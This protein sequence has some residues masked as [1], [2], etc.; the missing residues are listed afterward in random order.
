G[1]AGGTWTSGNTAV[2]SVDAAT[3]AV[4]GVAAGSTN[5][6]Y[7]STNGCGSARASA[8]IVVNPLP[9]AGTITE[10]A[11]AD[12]VCS[13]ATLLVSA[14]G[15]AGG[16]WSS[17]DATIASIDAAGN[18]YAG[19][20]GSATLT[21]LVTNG[22]DR[23]SATYNVRT[24][25][26]PATAVI[27]GHTTVNVGDTIQLSA[28]VAG[29]TWSSD[30]T[31]I[32]TVDPVGV[33]T[34]V[35]D[36]TTTISYTTTTFCGS[37]YGLYSVT[38]STPRHAPSFDSGAAVHLTVCENA[39][40]TSINSL[41][42]TTD[43][44]AGDILTFS[45]LS[46]AS[47]GTAAMSYVTSSTGVSLVPLTASYTPTTGYSGADAFSVLVSDGTLSDTI[48]V[49]VTVNPL[50]I[51]GTIS[52]AAG[53]TSVC[54]G[55]NLA[56]STTGDATGAWTSDNTAVA[57]VDGATGSV[58][59]VAAGTANIS[60]I[61]TNSCG[62]DTAT[63]AI[64]VN[65]LPDAG[66]ITGA[67]Q[68]CNGNT[69]AL[70]NTATGGTWS[71]SDVAVAS[72]DATGNVTSVAA[73]TAIISYTSTTA[74]GTLVDTQ[75]VTVL[76][77]PV[78]GT[79]SSSVGATMC[80]SG[81]TTLTS[82]GTT[83]GSWSMTN[84]AA[85]VDATGLV[86]ATAV[87]SAILDTAV[88]IVSNI[89]SSDTA[90]FTLVIDPAPN[91]GTI[92]GG[93]EV[94]NG[95]S[96]TLTN[97]VTGG[98]WS[99]SDATVASVD[100]VG[101]VTTVAAGTAVVTYTSTTFC[102]TLIDT[103]LVN[104]LIAPTAGIISGA[105]GADSV[106]AS[107]TLALSTTGTTGGS[108]S[109]DNIAVAFVDVA[110]GLVSGIGAGTAN[111]SYIVSNICGADT[112]T[113]TVRILALPDAGAIAGGHDVCNGASLTLTN[114]ATG[115]VWSSSNA[116]VASVDA[117]GSVTTV[118]VGSA[119]ISYTSTTSCGALVD[120]QLVNVQFAPTAGTITGA[121]GADSVCAAT[122][123]ALSTT[124]TSGGTW[125]TSD[126]AV[127][128]VNPA[129]GSVFGVTSGIATIS[130]IVSNSCSADT[131]TFDVRVLALPNAGTIN[132]GHEVCTGNTL[133][134]SNL[135]PGGIWSTTNAAIASVDATGTVTPVAAG[136][137]IISYTSTTSCGTQADTQAVTVLVPPTAGTISGAFGSDSACVGTN[138]SLSTTGTTGG[139]WSTSNVAIASVNAATGVVR[140]VSAGVATISYIVANPCSADTAVFNFNALPQPDAGTITGGNSVCFGNTLSLSNT[141]TGGSWSTSNA[142]VASVDNS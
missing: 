75:A 132:G 107:G 131:A 81:T 4:Y 142:S 77:A 86:T 116:A 60:Y 119:I 108:W 73:G 133:A 22:C 61:V 106:C 29:G 87:T 139:S 70:S 31:T 25:A 11:G 128:S 2:A 129:T 84:T 17:S 14:S 135:V 20:T 8:P 90:Y 68:V 100:A 3:G 34:G 38:S 115:G 37:A 42:A 126:V 43:I 7:T 124:G 23:D 58:T 136:S 109:S 123:L 40:V 112:A 53:A 137:A 76:V 35:G 120:T 117:T 104:V 63:F 27:S 45:I 19:N 56:L 82:S 46:G 114:T 6:T 134:L 121:G 21:Y 78:A 16:S 105:A 74:C 24:L 59:G 88:Y 41:L 9:V 47:H 64:T 127:A 55:S 80:A 111:I 66:S 51:A 28:S 39:A 110:T 125:S 50:P 62:A 18:V 140:A 91:A 26:L 99:T 103:Q 44:D 79:I 118:S 101:N 57:L 69:L 13:G 122:N 33:V 89:C 138:L 130:Y 12:T 30:I 71:T 49:N 102:G 98:S 67:Q 95:S 36:G 15:D 141:A 113:F 97:T 85:S 92:A 65:A 72:V 5:I 93:N 94:C 96:L 54:A 48:M 52:G 1:D 32:A 83:G 10:F